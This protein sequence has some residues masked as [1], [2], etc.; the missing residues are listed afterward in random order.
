MPAAPL[1]VADLEL[2][3]ELWLALEVFCDVFN[4]EKFTMSENICCTRNQYDVWTRLERRDLPSTDLE[5][6]TN[7]GSHFRVCHSSRPTCPGPAVNRLHM[8]C[9][10]LPFRGPR[11]EHL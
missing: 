1:D 6:K 8:F 9:R 5:K 10:C 7:D 11:G 3:L 2:E 4:A